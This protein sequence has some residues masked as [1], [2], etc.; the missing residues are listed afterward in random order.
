MP[1]C[2]PGSHSPPASSPPFSPHPPSS[3][4][5]T[6]APNFAHVVAP[7]SS[8]LFFLVCD[9]KETLATW[10]IIIQE[11]V[12]TAKELGCPI[13]PRAA[14]P[15]SLKSRRPHPETRRDAAPKGAF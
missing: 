11:W 6:E 15:P 14:A 3:L 4:G 5:S 12:E 2:A 10:K 13:P 1:A 7:A 9:S 8:R